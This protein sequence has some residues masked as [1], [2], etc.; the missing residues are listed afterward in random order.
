[1]TIIKEA[2]IREGAARPA[3]A[4]AVT[5]ARETRLW[6]RILAV[7]VVLIALAAGVVA[8]LAINNGAIDD[9][10]ADVESLE[11]D[12]QATRDQLTDVRLDLLAETSGYSLEREHLA[13]AYDTGL[14]LG[15]IKEHLAQATP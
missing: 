9:L 1:M 3:E 11:V 7:A 13:Q 6:P 15:M 2:P 12:L 5:P 14:S 8:G 4:P 10:R